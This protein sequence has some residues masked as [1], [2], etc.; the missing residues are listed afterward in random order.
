MVKYPMWR[1]VR[2]KVADARRRSGG[3]PFTNL[4]PLI[5]GTLKPGNPDIYYGAR[6]EQLTHEVRD[7][8]GGQIIPSTQH[9]LPIAPN[10][11][12]SAKSLGGSAAVAK[13]QACYDGALGVRGMHSVQLSGRDESVSDN[14]AYTITSI[15]RDGTLKMNTSHL[16]QPTSP[17]DRPEYHMTQLN[18]YSMTGN[19]DA[20]T[21]CEGARAYRNGRDLAK[22]Q[23]DDAIRQANERAKPVE[24][25]Y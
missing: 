12:L 10:L 15:Y 1:R 24:A 13:R 5:D 11:F 14:N 6:P 3:I 21:F 20:E 4:D 8:L 23:R 18:R 16:T 7:E 2:N 19:A 17:G 9:D 25:K 22:K